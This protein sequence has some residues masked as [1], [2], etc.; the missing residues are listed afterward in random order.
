MTLLS[1][2][3]SFTF[4]PPCCGISL[5]GKHQSWFEKFSRPNMKVTTEFW[6]SYVCCF[7]Y[8]PYSIRTAFSK[9]ESLIPVSWE[10]GGIFMF[11]VCF[12]Y[13]RW[14]M[15]M[16]LLSYCTRIESCNNI[17]VWILSSNFFNRTLKLYFLYCC[18]HKWT[19]EIAKFP[20]SKHSCEDWVWQQYQNLDTLPVT[21][22]KMFKSWWIKFQITGLQL[23]KSS[24]DFG[25]LRIDV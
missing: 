24:I 12:E 13:F 18:F 15:L 20:S 2:E 23:L 14:G 19:T 9:L 8:N 21:P 16:M 22:W 6:C 10:H 1:A 11:I 4:F 3:L 5:I 25:W 17:W 7:C